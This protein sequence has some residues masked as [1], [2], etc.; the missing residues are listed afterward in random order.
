MRKCLLAVLLLCSCANP[1]PPSGGPQDRTPPGIASSVPTAGAV[2]V[3]PSSLRLVFSEYVD[4]RSF[5]QAV[6]VTPDFDAPLQFSWGRRSVEVIFPEQLREQTTYR[7]TI[8]TGFQD[9]RGVALRRPVTL[10]FATGA[11]I[12]RGRI[13]GR[14]L[15]GNTGRPAP[16]VHVYAYPGG[17]PADSLPQPAYRTQTAPDGGFVFTYLREQP[18]YVVALE[19]N[20]RNRMRDPNEAYA[21]PPRPAILA[22]TAE[23]RTGALWWLGMPRDPSAPRPRFGPDTFT[24]DS[25]LWLTTQQRPVVRFDVALDS[26]AAQAAL[27]IR[28]TSD[29]TRTFTAHATDSTTYALDVLPRLAPDEILTVMLTRGDSTYHQSYARFAREQLGSLAGVVTITDT[30]DTVPTAVVQLYSDDGRDLQRI[31]T[32]TV[33]TDGTFTFR[34]LPEGRYRLRAFLDREEDHRW[35]VGRLAP[36]T[37]SE[38]MTWTSDSVRVRARWETALADTLTFRR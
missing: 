37:P 15:Q 32:T 13:L 6:S 33:G 12:N 18:Y 1:A 28:D 17:P 34:Y 10:A 9:A 2:R 25:L 22:D 14:V 30:L 23:A 21:V 7:V 5:E 31:R 11:R 27:G 36:Y 4:Q 3:R 24:R 19:D 16:N 29:T 8:G 26:A 35:D 38:P 20:N